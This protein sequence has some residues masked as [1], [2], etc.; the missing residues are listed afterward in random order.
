MNDFP[1]YMRE[2]AE[3]LV[4]PFRR[5]INH[6]PESITAVTSA[7]G[8]RALIHM[9]SGELSWQG[10]L[11]AQLEGPRLASLAKAAI[12]LHNRLI[13]HY[14]LPPIRADRVAAI[15]P[16]VFGL[17]RDRF[18]STIEQLSLGEDGQYV[19]RTTAPIVPDIA[20]RARAYLFDGD[21]HKEHFA[22]TYALTMRSS[23]ALRSKDAHSIAADYRDALLLG[24]ETEYFP[25]GTAHTDVKKMAAADALES[26]VA[27]HLFEIDLPDITAHQR[28]VFAYNITRPW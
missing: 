16:F 9:E 5:A 17:S 21:E 3:Q 22:S 27:A 8:T 24:K 6:V 11:D 12:S 23:E 19:A 20:E 28:E 14:E 26:V 25:T 10:L 7:M 18:V 13:K 2:P 1:N 15:L 4:G